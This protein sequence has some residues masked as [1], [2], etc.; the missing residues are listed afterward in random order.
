MNKIADA[1]RKNKH[2]YH[3]NYHSSNHNFNTPYNVKSKNKG[4]WILEKTKVYKEE[5]IEKKNNLGD[6]YIKFIRFAEW[7]MEGVDRGI[8]GVIKNN[9]F[10]DGITH[11]QMRKHLLQNFKPRI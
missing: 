10:Y 11:R 6:D 5:L 9:S 8:I 3:G 1:L 2:N 4:K 7:K